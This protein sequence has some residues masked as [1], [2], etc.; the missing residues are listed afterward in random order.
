MK[1][2]DSDAV[3]HKIPL[4]NKRDVSL[5]NPVGRVQAK[6][7][8]ESG[9]EL[10]EFSPDLGRHSGKRS[11]RDSDDD[12]PER[13][14]DIVDF[15]GHDLSEITPEISDVVDDMMGEIT[16]LRSELD[17]AQN[18]ISFM[19]G[20]SDH[21]PVAGCLSAPAFVRHVGQVLLLD[22]KGGTTSSLAMMTIKDWE[23]IHHGMNR[24]ADETV[25]SHLGRMLRDAV[26]IGDVV[27][28]TAD[29]EFAIIFVASDEKEAQGFLNEIQILLGDNPPDW[30]NGHIQ[31]EAA[32]MLMS[33]AQYSE[34][35]AVMADA[36]RLMRQVLKE[37]E[38]G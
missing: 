28:H 32:W 36:D 35:D 16:R 3:R 37:Q 30:A 23:A 4:P 14:D 2:D 1:F 13:S 27:G 8:P 5:V 11:P 20:L 7:S 24:K 33:L 6:Y 12:R 17:I 29:D 31:I 38:N 9:D 18:R 10:P 34:A 21:D 26:R 19:E 15:H 25:I 22:Q